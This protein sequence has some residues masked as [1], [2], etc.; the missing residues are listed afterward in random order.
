MKKKNIIDFM[1]K[2]NIIDWISIILLILL[3][4]CIVSCDIRSNDE[5]REE[6]YNIPVYTTVYDIIYPDS[7]YRYTCISYTISAENTIKY[8]KCSKLILGYFLFSLILNSIDI[9]S[10]GRAISFLL[11]CLSCDR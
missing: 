11:Q 10:E 6:I 4:L 7:T 8:P 5:P 1:K 9:Y 3:L 2:T